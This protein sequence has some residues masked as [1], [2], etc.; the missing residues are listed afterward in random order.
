M[1]N[2]IIPTPLRK[3]TN[4]LPTLESDG[5]TVIEVISDLSG[6]FPEL[7]PHLFDDQC[8]IRKFIRIFVGDEDIK[9]LDNEATPVDENSVVS[10]VP[11]IAGG[12]R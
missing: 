1:A 3:F 5:E 4:N 10:I 12:A 11:A 2:I 9:A 6:A 7:K 8:D